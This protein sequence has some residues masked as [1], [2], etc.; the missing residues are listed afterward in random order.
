MFMIRRHLAL[1]ALVFAAW[2][3]SPGAPSSSDAEHVGRSSEAIIHGS[4]DTTHTAVVALILGED[5]T[6]G[7]CSGTIVKTDVAAQIGWVATAAHCVKS[8]V[9]FAVQGEDFAA[10]NTIAYSVLDYEADPEYT[11]FTGHDFAV[12]RIAGIDATTPVIPLTTDPDNLTEGTQVTAVGFGVTDKS[13]SGLNTKRHYVDKPLSSVQAALISY[14]QK[15]SG[16]CFGDSGGPDLVGSGSG[17]RVVGI[18]SFVSGA[19]PS[20]PCSGTGSSSRVTD[21]LS[22]ITAQLEKAAPKASCEL[23][24]KIANSGKGACSALTAACLDDDNCKNYTTCITDKSKTE[25]D[26]FDA[27]PLA[28][29]PFTASTSCVC[30][31]C[32]AECASD[33]ACGAVGKCGYKLPADDC[34]SCV[35]QSCCDEE[36][37]CTGDAQCYVCLKQGDATTSCKSNDPRKKLAAC[38]ADKCAAQCASSTIATIGDSKSPPE[39][40]AGDSLPDAP[41]ATTSSCACSETPSRSTAA[42]WAALLGLSAFIVRRRRA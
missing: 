16:T 12:I 3:C 4:D 5:A 26:C 30:E 35:E 29:G 20:T 38:A 10:T 8:G 24:R 42:P 41:A 2:A 33:A 25:A 31:A 37:A 39:P 18:H 22:F 6:E 28:E 17:Q 23:C 11:G 40:D 21:G 27:Y 9:S 15:E 19:S 14:E 36:L 7:T 32:A 34:S 13:G 1:G